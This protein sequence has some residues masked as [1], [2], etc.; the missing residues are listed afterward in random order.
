MGSDG[1]VFLEQTGIPDWRGV[2]TGAW[3]CEFGQ[4]T[5]TNCAGTVEGLTTSDC[6]AWGSR[7]PRLLRRGPKARR[8]V[9]HKIGQLRWHIFPARSREQSGSKRHRDGHNPRRPDHGRQTRSCPCIVETDQIPRNPENPRGNL[10]HV[11]GGLRLAAWRRVE[12]ADLWSEGA[13]IGCLWSPAERTRVEFSCGIC[14]P[15][16]GFHHSS[17]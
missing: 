3:G 16:W 10:A 7:P 12:L 14:P 11:G 9:L 17:L 15:W 8:C 6:C 4:E 5:S 2:S 13:A 1:V